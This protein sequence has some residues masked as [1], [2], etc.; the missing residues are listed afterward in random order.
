MLVNIYNNL[1][2]YSLPADN[3]ILQKTNQDHFILC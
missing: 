3:C 1:V 2:D